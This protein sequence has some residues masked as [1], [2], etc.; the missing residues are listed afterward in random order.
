MKP[1]AKEDPSL[2]LASAMIFGSSKAIELQEASGQGELVNSDVLPTDGLW[3]VRGIIESNGGAIGCPV[4]DDPI[5][6]DV[7]LPPGWKKKPT[8]HSMWSKLVDGK[9]RE[10]AAIFYKAAFYD[11]SAHIRPCRRFNI[12]TYGHSV[13]DEA[14]VSVKD[15]EGTVEFSTETIKVDREQRYSTIERLT[16]EVT[17]FLDEKFPDWKS[18]EAHWS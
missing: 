8:D 4:A 15:A 3:Q 14:K 11:R 9:G 13:E 16:A 17:A 18:P 5:F 2:I 10:R 7:T 1:T 6:T 12:D